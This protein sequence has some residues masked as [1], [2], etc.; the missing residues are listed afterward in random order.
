[1]ADEPNVQQAVPFLRVSDIQASMRF[2][3]DGL[4][5]E[6]TQKWTP[7]GKLRWCWLQLGGAAMML[8]EYAREGLDSWVPESKMGVGV[9]VVFICRDAL[10]IY[11]LA[12]SRG[13]AASEPFVGNGMWSTTMSDPDGY[14]IEFE[15]YTDVPEETRLA[16]WEG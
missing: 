6:M 8:Q 13:I 3:V 2:Y 14:R 10:A 12:L 1:M 9:S 16:E 11:R 5:F 15:S 4:G 7:Q